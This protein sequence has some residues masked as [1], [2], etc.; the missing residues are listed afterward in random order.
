MKFKVFVLACSIAMMG[1]AGS[2]ANLQ[3][4]VDALKKRTVEQ[5]K[6]IAELKE[7]TKSDTSEEAAKAW[8]WIKTQSGSAWD[9][10]KSGQAQDKFKR[11]WEE[12]NK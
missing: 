12:L 2:N 5:D 10:V 7:K 9:S 11:C 8:A 3:T 1:C 6:Q 4:E